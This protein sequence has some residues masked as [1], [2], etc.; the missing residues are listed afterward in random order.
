MW[1]IGVV[2]I[3]VI[4]ACVLAIFL[5]GGER[6][7]PFVSLSKPGSRGKITTGRGRT[8]FQDHLRKPPNENELL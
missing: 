3:V 7:G 2:V 6:G 4:A 8:D 1:I 5:G